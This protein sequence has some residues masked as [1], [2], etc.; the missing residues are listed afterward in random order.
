MGHPVWYNLSCGCRVQEDG[1]KYAIKDTVLRVCAVHGLAGRIVDKDT[2]CATCGEKMTFKKTARCPENCKPCAAAIKAEM[3][4]VYGR[5][6]MKKIRMFAVHKVQ[7]PE[8]ANFDLCGDCVDS[9]AFPCRMKSIIAGE[10]GQ[11]A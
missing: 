3:A 1:L 11:A 9:V 10:E 7:R 2:I 6:Y 8:C 4:R 5:G